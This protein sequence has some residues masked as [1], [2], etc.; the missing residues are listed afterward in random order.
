MQIQHNP[1]DSRETRFSQ[2]ELL[3]SDDVDEF[4]ELH[5]PAWDLCYEQMSAGSFSAE[6][7]IRRSESA[8]AYRER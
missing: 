8:V 2:V 4:A 6:K 5:R 1:V 7:V 3:A